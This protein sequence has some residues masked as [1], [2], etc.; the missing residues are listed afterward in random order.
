MAKTILNILSDETVK[1]K[2]KAKTTTTAAMEQRQP[3]WLRRKKILNTER[4]LKYYLW[5]IS[6]N[7]KSTVFA[8]FMGVCVCEWVL[9]HRERFKSCMLFFLDEK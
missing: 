6:W 5:I 3:I 1:K 9:W 8:L 7:K 4:K 2:H